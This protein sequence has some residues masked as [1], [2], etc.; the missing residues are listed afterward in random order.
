MNSLV[1]NLTTT[2][3]RKGTPRRH[4]FNGTICS[5]NLSIHHSTSCCQNPRTLVLEETYFISPLRM[6]PGALPTL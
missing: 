4:L 1:N 2:V 3:Q 6:G 5:Q